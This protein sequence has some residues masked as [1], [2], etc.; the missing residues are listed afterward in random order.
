MKLVIS[1]NDKQH[2]SRSRERVVIGGVGLEGCKV[3]VASWCVTADGEPGSERGTF[4]FIFGLAL[5]KELHD[6]GAR[7][8]PYAATVWTAGVP[9]GG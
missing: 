7:K 3:K 5:R 1:R 4:F 8:R 6:S 2:A 9:R